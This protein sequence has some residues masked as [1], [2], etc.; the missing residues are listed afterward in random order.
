MDSSW[1]CNTPLPLYLREKKP[2]ESQE[3]WPVLPR[4]SSTPVPKFPWSEFGPQK[5]P[6]GSVQCQESRTETR[7]EQLLALKFVVLLTGCCHRASQP[8]LLGSLLVIT[9]NDVLS[10]LILVVTYPVFL[11]SSSSC[12]Y[13]LLWNTV[14]NY[15]RVCPLTLKGERLSLP[16]NHT[17]HGCWDRLTSE[18]VM[19]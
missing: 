15:E 1:I 18:S 11:R 6:P 13:S 9:L 5:W 10:V 12:W 14:P 19:C 16:P 17:Q 3:N 7:E 8:M 2:S 4:H